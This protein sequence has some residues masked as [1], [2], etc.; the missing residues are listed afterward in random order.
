MIVVRVSTDADVDRATDILKEYV[1]YVMD[2]RGTESGGRVDWHT[3]V[4]GFK[5]AQFDGYR[6]HKL[7]GED[8]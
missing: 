2:W 5:D 7:R 1:K 8:D 3:S 6:L 4:W